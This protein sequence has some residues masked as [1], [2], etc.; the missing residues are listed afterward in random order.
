M[1]SL[2]IYSEIG[3][4]WGISSNEVADFLNSNK[5]QDVEIRINSPG[6]SVTEGIAIY[7]LLKNHSGNVSIVVDS[8][9]ASISTIIALGGDSLTMNLGSMFMIHNPWM[10][11][12]GDSEDLRKEANVLDA[13]KEQLINIYMT[14][15]E[16]SRDELIA[17][18]DEESWLSDTEAM[19]F[20]FVDSIEQELKISA[21]VKHNLKKY[22]NTIPNKGKQMKAQEKDLEVSAVESPEVEIKAEEVTPE[23]EIKSEEEQEEEM[24]EEEAKAEDSEEEAPAEEP[25][26]ELEEEAEE[27]EEETS[28]AKNKIDPIKAMNAKIEAEVEARIS[29]EMNRQKEIKSL[30]FN[31]QGEL[32]D[33]LIEE[34][35]SLAEASIRLI[36]NKK[37]M[38]LK[39]PLAKVNESG[40]AVALEAKDVL[41]S[42]AQG[43]PKNLNEGL[44]S[45]DSDSLESLRNQM[46]KATDKEERRILSMKISAKKKEIAIG[47]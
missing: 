23:A 21:S 30:A 24:K 27:S 13:M 36:E 5:D 10:M 43:A 29:A 9:C 18:M 28:E 32:V 1:N 40:E 41:D 38:D 2:L 15:F 19:K 42:M 12:F 33:S 11:T 25:E 16:G 20:G 22:F 46:N 17:M 31:G 39:A 14:K 47:R 4:M 37:E 44:A 34:K 3:G 8:L 26:K 45:E 6:G 35:V 7:N